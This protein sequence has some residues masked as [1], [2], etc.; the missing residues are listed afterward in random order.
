MAIV[1]EDGTLVS[2]ANSY[3]TL[4]EFKAWADDRGITYGTDSAISQQLYRAHDYFEGLKFKG[5]KADENQAMQWPRDQVLIDGYAVDSNEIPKEVKTALYE[6]IKIEIDG[7]S[8]LSPSERE[9]TSEQVDSIKITYKDN[10]GMKRSTPA[11]ERAL[12][13]LVLPFSE[14]TRA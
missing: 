2:G 14:V 13:K 6:L 7:D 10:S 5:L 9:V 12:R 11:L 3:I 4:A 1:V 8:K